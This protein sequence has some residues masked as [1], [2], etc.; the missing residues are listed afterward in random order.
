MLEQ[1]PALLWLFVLV[2]GPIIL[3]L[4]FAFTRWRRGRRARLASDEVTR[5]RFENDDFVTPRE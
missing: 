5:R 3:G 1:I 4:L 2:G